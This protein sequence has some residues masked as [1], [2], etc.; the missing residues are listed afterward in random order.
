MCYIFLPIIYYYS[1]YSYPINRP[2]VTY[3]MMLVH[4]ETYSVLVLY[5]NII[6]LI[7]NELLIVVLTKVMQHIYIFTFRLHKINAL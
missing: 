1:Y 7:S 3:C 4:A 2:I 5:Q 6:N